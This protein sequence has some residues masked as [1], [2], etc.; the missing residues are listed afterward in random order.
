[1]NAM[2]FR[3]DLRVYDNPALSASVASGQT[4]AFYC[5]SEWEWDKHSVSHAQRA[6]IL[7]HLQ[8]L[9]ES[10]AKLNVP[11]IIFKSDSAE[12]QV[13]QITD[14][15]KS[16][17]V[18]CCYLNHQ[19]EANEKQQTE[20]VAA[21]LANCKIQTVGFDDQCAIAPGKIT[22]QNGSCYK[23]YSAFKRAY[24]KAYFSE[25]R[26]IAEVPTKQADLTELALNSRHLVN[27]SDLE[28]DLRSALL[29]DKSTERF[30]WCINEDSVHQL[31]ETFL[32]NKA[33][34]YKR[35]R[36]FP[37][38]SATSTLS[39]Y[40][41]I[42]V[43]STRQCFELALQANRG[44]FEEGNPG[45]ITWINE[46]IWREFYRHLVVF[47]PKLSKHQ[48]FKSHTDALPWRH[49][50]DRFQRW[51]DGQT[52]FPIVDAAMRQLNE[53][54]WM[55]NRLRMITAMFL[56][57]DLF[58]DWRLGE[59]YFMSKL[60]DGDLAS[61]NGGWQWSASTGVD[62]VPYFRIFNPTRQSERFD[63]E[64]TFI[65][66][67]V[68]ELG[69]L[70]GKSIHS[71]T[72]IQRAKCGYPE[73][74]VDHSLAATQTKLWFKECPPEGSSREVKPTESQETAMSNQSSEP[75]QSLML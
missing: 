57:K 52:G 6:L 50:K 72:A 10:L 45:V 20:A 63:P 8:A 28:V 31:L 30:E 53:T 55:H 3:R 24:I 9:T 54:G 17:G 16:N 5:L 64:G 73:P 46:L 43:I 23:V 71:P 67:F 39:P 59:E 70:T 25:V 75:Q 27:D 15:L 37:S 18:T 21:A 40:Q 29:M 69:S 12:Q 65:K 35:D 66:Q 2:W 56:T 61:N 7:T 38:L 44:H 1:M 19:Y 4:I 36:D 42:G 48:A 49:D 34:H 47:Y 13:N 58:I 62:A 11:L 60:I 33:V 26:P 22:N 74:M 68:P 14:L 51:C 32:E 41:A